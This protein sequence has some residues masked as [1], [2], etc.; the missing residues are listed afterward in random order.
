ML[1]M[2]TCLGDSKMKCKT[3]AKILKGSLFCLLTVAA[4]VQAQSLDT[5]DKATD[6]PYL[7]KPA[8]QS[9]AVFENGFVFQQGKVPTDPQGHLSDCSASQDADLH[10]RVIS[11]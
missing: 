8:V 10:L 1:P 5:D 11:I 9:V 7:W 3:K 2:E 4:A 6:N